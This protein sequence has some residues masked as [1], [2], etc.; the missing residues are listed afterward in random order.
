MVLAT[1][2]ATL[3]ALYVYSAIIAVAG[4]VLYSVF[5]PYAKSVG[6]G[7]FEYGILTAILTL[8][9][10]LSAPIWGYLS[11]KVDPRLLLAIAS[12]TGSSIFLFLLIKA[13][14]AYY[15]AAMMAGVTVGSSA[16]SQGLVGKLAEDKDKGFAYLQFSNLIG[17]A[18]GALLVLTGL[19][20]NYNQAFAFGAMVMI[21]SLAPLAFMKRVSFKVS[22]PKLSELKAL[23]RAVYYIFAFQLILAIGAAAG[24]WMIDYYFVKKYNVG[25][26]S[27]GLYVFL[28]QTS[29]ALMTLLVPDLSKREGRLKAYF[30]L[31]IPA[32]VLTFMVTLVNDFYLALALIIARGALI[33]AGNPIIDA[34]LADFTP[35]EIM[36][37][38]M[39]ILTTLNAMGAT[40]GRLIGGYLMEIDVELPLRFTALM[41]AL[42][43]GELGLTIGRRSKARTS[44]VR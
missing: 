6:I 16:V 40:L 15:M 37:T 39:G 44:E 26:R 12:F 35:K 14:W 8:V 5:A 31:A 11:D 30:L 28:R 13:K 22:M 38:V 3:R 10:M 25:M 2:R 42:G 29:I 9:G 27:V 36:G 32:T 4:S 34:I 24:V 18:L 43:I 17:G 33:N 20:S 19:F 21:F 1:F 23:P 41:Y 7:P